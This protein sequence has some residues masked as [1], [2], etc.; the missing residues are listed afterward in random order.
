V[1]CI[2]FED[3]DTGAAA[4]MA[5]GMVVV[6]VPDQVATDGRHATHLADD[7][8]AGARKAGLI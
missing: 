8:I 3:S 5:A 2:A 1:R 7:L 4:A 6:Q